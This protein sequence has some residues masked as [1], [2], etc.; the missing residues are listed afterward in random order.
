MNCLKELF[1]QRWHP[2]NCPHL[3]LLL[4]RQI[5]GPAS[6]PYEPHL[7]LFSVTQHP[8]HPPISDFTPPSVS[9]FR[10]WRIDNTA[11]GRQ[12]PW[13]KPKTQEV[14][15]ARFEPRPPIC[16]TPTF[17]PSPP[18]PH[19][20]HQIRPGSTDSSPQFSSEEGL[21]FPTDG[22]ELLK[23]HRAPHYMKGLGNS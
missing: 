5:L 8:R 2:H 10:H 22:T 17:P 6:D 15:A 1:V 18:C 23:I 4:H 9:P 12:G 13:P 11:R 21:H 3:G 7:R 20:G 14:A 16:T 19:L